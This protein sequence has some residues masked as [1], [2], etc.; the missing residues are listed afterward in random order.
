MV[1]MSTTAI[2]S[3]VPVADAAAALGVNTSRVRQMLLAGQLTGV[4]VGRRSWLVNADSL[5]KLRAKRESGKKS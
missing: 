5:D 2:I 3:G 1:G 4:R